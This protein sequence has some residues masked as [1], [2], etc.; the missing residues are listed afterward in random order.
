MDHVKSSG[1]DV[2][3]VM[4]GEIFVNN[5][6]FTIQLQQGSWNAW[7]KAIRQNNFLRQGLVESPIAEAFLCDDVTNM[8]R[9][10]RMIIMFQANLS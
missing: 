7:R 5:F 1:E 2:K 9:M 10:L 6:Q 4:P 3:T 8:T